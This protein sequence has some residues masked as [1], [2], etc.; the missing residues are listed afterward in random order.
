M[1]YNINGGV[2]TVTGD[3]DWLEVHAGVVYLKG[4]VKTVVHI[5]GEIYDQR[6]S[7]RVEYRTD[8]ISDEE[9]SR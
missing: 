4:N 5:G 1:E 3:V 2:N 9:L 7:N 6:P 8:H